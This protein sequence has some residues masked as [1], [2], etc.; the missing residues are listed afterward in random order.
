M[1]LKVRLKPTFGCNVQAL[2]G[3]AASGVSA[4]RCAR[5]DHGVK[6]SPPIIAIRLQQ[7]SDIVVYVIFDTYVPIYYCA[8]WA[9]AEISAV[10]VP[11]PSLLML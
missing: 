7:I 3:S 9:K 5:N 11:D 2:C 8:I 10:E 4:L 1:H 6:R